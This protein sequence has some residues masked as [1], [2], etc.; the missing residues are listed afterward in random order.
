[1]RKTIWILLLPLL[2]AALPGLVPAAT[3]Y[4]EKKGD[5]YSHAAPEE[6]MAL[7][8]YCWGHYDKRFQGPRYNIDTRVCGPRMN[9]FCPGIL[10]FNRS[11]NPLASKMERQGYLKQSIRNFDYSM[12]GLK[13]YAGCPQRKHV[14]LMQKRAR[15]AAMGAVP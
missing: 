14:L 7:P 10:R 1:M 11:Q 8:K 2:G 3:Y 5:S 12:E 6:L 4:D 13:G 9:H 15:M